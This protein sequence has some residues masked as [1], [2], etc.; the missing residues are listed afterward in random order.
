V[1]RSGKAVLP[2]AYGIDFGADMKVLTNLFVHAAIWRLDLDQEFVY[3]GDEGVIEPNGKTKRQGLD[4]SLRYQLNDW[5]F[6][7]VDMKEA[8]Q[9]ENYIPLAP[10]ASSV[11]GLSF[12]RKEGFNGSLRYRFMGDRPAIENNSV[13]A[14]GYFIADAMLNYTKPSYSIGIC[15]ENIFNQQWKETQFN[16]ES[17]LVN[18]AQPISEIHLT[19]GSPFGIKLRFTKTF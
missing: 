15:V 3:V 16:T 14:K 1:E 10:L 17:R 5:I 6:A 9:G 8:T 7:D 11:G 12:Q 2:K 19:P 4:L 13:I 18:E